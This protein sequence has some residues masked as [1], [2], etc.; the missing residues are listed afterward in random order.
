MYSISGGAS[1]TWAFKGHI[2]SPTMLWV[3]NYVLDNREVI[4]A[5]VK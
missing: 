2:F 3:K 5:I 1:V 4:S